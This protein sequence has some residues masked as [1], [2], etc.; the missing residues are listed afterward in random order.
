M[1]PVFVIHLFDKPLERSPGLGQIAVLL[2]VD[3]LGLPRLQETFR[4]G[5]IVRIPDPAHA[6][7]DRVLLQPIG[8]VLGGVLHPAIGVMHQARLRSSAG[9]GPLE[10][11]HR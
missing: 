7:R 9:Q 4:P 8:V 3:L 6:N 2:P 11:S 1:Q 10:G 5:M